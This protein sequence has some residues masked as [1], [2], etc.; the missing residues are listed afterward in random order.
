[1]KPTE[2]VEFFGLFLYLLIIVFDVGFIYLWN[3]YYQLS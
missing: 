1:M 3:V 2:V